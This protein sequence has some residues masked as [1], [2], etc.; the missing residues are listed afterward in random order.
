[1]ALVKILWKFTVKVS[2]GFAPSNILD[3]KFSTKNCFSYWFIYI[4]ECILYV[5]ENCD[6]PM[7][8]S[9]LILE[10]VYLF[11]TIGAACSSGYYSL[12][13]NTA[14]IPCPGGYQCSSAS[15][16]P[17]LCTAG[18][19][20]NNGSTSCTPCAAGYYCPTDGLSE[21]LTC[22]TGYYQTSTGQTSCTQ[23]AQ[24]KTR[25]GSHYV[26]FSEIITR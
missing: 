14:C 2:E 26:L 1:M 10:Y 24:G 19:Y 21:P 17:V 18:N 11:L 22:P 9:M 15:S 12:G 3:V 5:W 23:C 25:S 4:I 6:Y 13:G 7:V 16:N 20:A 8:K